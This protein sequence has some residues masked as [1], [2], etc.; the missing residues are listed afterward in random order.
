MTDTV[1]V[2]PHI[3]ELKVAWR[4]QD[5][6]FTKSQSE[7]Y[8]LLLQ[9]RRERVAEFYATGR[10]QVGPKKKPEEKEKDTDS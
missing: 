7:E 8:E 4:R 6:K 3:D 1:N 2:L 9:A 5:F 10:V